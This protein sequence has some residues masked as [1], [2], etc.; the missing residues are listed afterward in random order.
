MNIRWFAWVLAVLVLVG[1]GDGDSTHSPPKTPKDGST[2]TPDGA[3]PGDSGRNDTGTSDSADPCASCDANATCSTSG[4]M[5]A[6][7]CNQGFTGDGA[8]CTDIDECA[9]GTD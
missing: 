9:D 6:C 7:V 4:A 3:T 1:C 8:T 2:S 5:P